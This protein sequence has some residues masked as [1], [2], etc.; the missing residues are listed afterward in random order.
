MWTGTGL[1]FSFLYGRRHA[2]EL[3]HVAT[4]GFRPA[5]AAA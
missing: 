1:T 5:F 4:S 2:K 3:F